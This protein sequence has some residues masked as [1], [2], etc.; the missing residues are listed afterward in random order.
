MI[1]A[2]M[3]KRSDV[4]I[5]VAT[6]I[7]SLICA[8]AFPLLT[9]AATLAVF[10]LAHIACELRFVDQRFSSRMNTKFALMLGV[11]LA[12]IVCARAAMVFRIAPASIAFNA[13]LSLV[14]VLV[15]IA[16]GYM[17]ASNKT[18]RWTGLLFI[19]GLAFG[20]VISPVTTVL[21]LAVLHNLT[22]VGFIVELTPSP[23]RK[24]AL[25][26]TSLCLIGIPLLI[27][28][29]ALSWLLD[30]VIVRQ[31]NFSIFPTGPLEKHLG[32]FLPESMRGHHWSTN[33]FAGIVF[34]QCMHYLAVI[35]VM[36]R[37]IGPLQAEKTQAT[38]IKW[39]RSG[40]F[41]SI[42]LLSTAALVLVYTKNFAWARSLYSIV[43]VLHAYI[44]IPLLLW[45]F[46][47][48]TPALYS[49]SKR[50]VEEVAA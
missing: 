24:L 33:A 2:R 39:P 48:A 5:V 21:V 43:A 27:A 25:G 16:Y 22:P 28:S 18:M 41:W 12:L 34:A 7:A 30:L 44:E 1:A 45:A 15:L 17:P 6:I 31:E 14:L 36:P 9:Y 3:L 26:L 29:G 20:L 23:Q 11:V 13:E 19:A 35:F 10:G 4:M 46:A 37:L 50:S 49:S 32:A 40:W 8:T 47:S 38:F 42:V